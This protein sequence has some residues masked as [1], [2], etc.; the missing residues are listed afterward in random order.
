MADLFAQYPGTRMPVT[1]NRDKRGLRATYYDVKKMNRRQVDF[2]HRQQ[3]NAVQ[4]YEVTDLNSDNA[5]TVFNNKF[6]QYK[7]KQFDDTQNIWIY[8]D[9][10]EEKENKKIAKNPSR[11]SYTMSQRFRSTNSWRK[12]RRTKKGM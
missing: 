9:Q 4:S 6:R 1:I 5:K 3:E 10:F 11:W 2:C 12:K 8:K 7:I